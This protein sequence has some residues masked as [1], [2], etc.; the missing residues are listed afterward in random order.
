MYNTDTPKVLDSSA[1]ST[2]ELFSAILRFNFQPA[3][4]MDTSWWQP[5]WPSSELRAHLH[6]SRRA[7]CRL[8][9]II[10]HQ[11]GLTS[12]FDL[13]FAIEKK[14][15]A[16]LTPTRLMYLIKLAG[17][18]LQ[19]Q[20][21]ARAILRQDRESITATVGESD[22]RFALKH[23]T[24][25]LRKAGVEPVA[26]TDD[27]V[28]DTRFSTLEE[29]CRRFGFGAFA[30]AMQDMSTA[31]SRRLQLKLTKTDVDQYWHD[32]NAQTNGAVSAG[33]QSARFF[34][35]LNREVGAT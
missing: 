9:Q 32:A 6:K 28:G 14:R 34:L 4:Y 33:D 5:E 23:A 24:Q 16:L 35:I 3:G 15:L 10:L 29:D 1:V 7:Q 2:P 8:S 11:F 13:D 17:L 27:M 25:I 20:R 12:K 21:I 31:F 22:Y 18:I 30:L 19:I 26:I